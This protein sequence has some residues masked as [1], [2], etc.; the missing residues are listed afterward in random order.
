MIITRM[1]MYIIEII[2]MIIMA[3]TIKYIIKIKETITITDNKIITEIKTQKNTNKFIIET[4]FNEN[5][6]LILWLITILLII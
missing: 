6:L 1:N 2:I 3:M 5:L 4:I